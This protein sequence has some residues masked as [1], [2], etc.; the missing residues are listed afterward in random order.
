MLTWKHYAYI[1]DCRGAKMADSCENQIQQ[2]G[3]FNVGEVEAAKHWIKTAK[4]LPNEFFEY[5]P[6]EFGVYCG[7]QTGL[8]FPLGP[9]AIFSK[10][11]GVREVWAYY[12]L[13]GF[14]INP[15]PTP[16]DEQ[17]FIIDQRCG[18]FTI[19]A[20]PGTGK[21]STILRRAYKYASEGV[22]IISYSNKS[23]KI[24]KD[25]FMEYPRHRGVIGYKAYSKKEGP[26]PIVIATVDSLAHYITS[27]GCIQDADH[28][29]D[30]TIAEAIRALSYGKS[31]PFKHIIVDEAQ[32]IPD[33]RAQVILGLYASGNH[34]SLTIFGDP[35]Q[36][37]SAA[38]GWFSKLWAINQYQFSFFQRISGGADRLMV[39]PEVVED[40]D[41]N[42]LLAA[43]TDGSSIA[44]NTSDAAHS[45]TRG[46]KIQLFDP[47]NY[48][49][50]VRTIA[51]VKHSLSWCHRFKNQRLLDLH[52][53][54]SA[55]RPHLHV[56]LRSLQ[57]LPD[58]GPIR[59]YDIGPVY[60]ETGMID[61][62]KYLKSA[63]VDSGYC[64]QKDICFILPSIDKSN[65]TS[66]KAQ[67]LAAIIKDVG[68]SCYTRKEGSFQPEAI[69]I[70]TAYDSK[71]TEF[72]ITINYC[73]DEFPR[74]FPQIPMTVAEGL[75]YIFCTRSIKEMIFLSHG[76]FVPPKGVNPKFLSYSASLSNSPS[77]GHQVE[78]KDSKLEAKAVSVTEIVGHHGFLKLLHINNYLITSAPETPFATRDGSG[79]NNPSKEEKEEKE[80]NFPKLPAFNIGTPALNGVLAGLVIETLVGNRHLNIFYCLVNS[81]YIVMDDIQYNS[82]VRN[83]CICNGVWNTRDNNFGK[84]VIK[85]EVVNS[86]RDVEI[87]RLKN[88]IQRSILSLDYNQW[89]F[90]AQ[91]TSWIAGDNMNARYDLIEVDQPF[92]IDEFVAVATKLLSLFS[93]SSSILNSEGV[94]V[95]KVLEFGYTM[96]ACDI[97][98]HDLIVEL[99][100]TKTITN[101]HRH[102]VLLYN[103]CLQ[104]PRHTAVYNLKTG[105]FELVTSN[106]NPYDWRYIMDAFVTIKN[107]TE[108]VTCRQNRG[109]IPQRL[110]PPELYVADTEFFDTIFDFAMVN[111]NDP[112]TS[113]VQPLR[114]HHPKAP[115]WLADHH[116]EWKL[117][118][119]T[120]LLRYA[121]EDIST[122]FAKLEVHAKLQNSTVLYYTA[123]NDIVYPLKYGMKGFDL[124]PILRAKAKTNGTSTE[125]AFSIRLGEIYDVLVTPMDFQPHLHQHLALT[126]SL[127]LYE[128]YHLGHLD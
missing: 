103:A 84:V 53:D 93:P 7:L 50:Q 110:A 25:D 32:S 114:S 92:P 57:P 10:V 11:Y 104:R 2:L 102:Q 54:L 40:Q 75:I 38:G 4:S 105:V 125:A 17:Q 65:L 39:I 73:F 16:T 37:N 60:S 99:K 80:G 22:L 127:L 43:I 79:S 13:K 58:L 64:K 119:L 20:G 67:R 19:N 118:E 82:A 42:D 48:Q 31:I 122:S 14:T 28:S 90:L 69:C 12:L 95:E 34:T 97:L 52:N 116:K 51:T 77:T 36:I 89:G 98:F 6:S 45:D 72:P 27:K 68:L 111:L 113:I 94:E 96:G 108:L 76:K 106:R 128:F 74:Y 109:G 26:Y 3:L 85:R 55:T 62:I 70:T 29:Y 78:R 107:H 87:E 101:Q 126:D 61:F 8:V 112:Y 66:R 86:I 100:Y 15:L 83:G 115:I 30:D 1:A 120:E 59:C 124:A 44:S 24:I 35:R 21:T 49:A 9:T 56:P 33:F 81:Q 63:Y 91:L 123:K 46:V 121:P 5:T 23:T 117:Q 47:N 18:C 71:G 88:I 41:M